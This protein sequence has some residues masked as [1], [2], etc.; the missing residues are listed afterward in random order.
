MS[1]NQLEKLL[2]QKQEKL[3]K[4]YELTNFL[5]GQIYSAYLTCNRGN[6]KCTR[7]EKHGPIWNLTWKEN[8]KTKTFY[9]RKN[10]VDKIKEG[11]QE[12]KTIKE[13]IK[14]ISFLNLEIFKK[15]R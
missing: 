1:K 15:N 4:L 9:V 7:G 8:K 3:N 12:H 2:K 6:C 10:E 11:C 13:L 14:E 5:P